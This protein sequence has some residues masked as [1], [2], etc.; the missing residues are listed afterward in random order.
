MKAVIV[1][2]AMV[3]VACLLAACAPDLDKNA[4]RA[5]DLGR[6]IAGG[7]TSCLGT[8]TGLHCFGN[9]TGAGAVAHDFNPLTPKG[10]GSVKEVSM[11]HGSGFNSGCV[12]SDI[13]ASGSAPELKDV[14]YCWVGT[15][16]PAP[17]LTS[18]GSP[19]TNMRGLSAGGGQDCA[20]EIGT[21]TIFCWHTPLGSS[22]QYS[23]TAG[24]VGNLGRWKMISVASGGLF[25]C[26]VGIRTDNGAQR[27]VCWGANDQGQLG[28]GTATPGDLVAD[29]VTGVVGPVALSAG[30][31]HACAILGDHSVKCWGANAHG[32]VGIGDA[33]VTP[34]TTPQVVPGLLYPQKISAGNAFTCVVL[35][36]QTARCWG[37]NDFGQLGIGL[38]VSAAGTDSDG[39]Y[40]V[41]FSSPI[42][43]ASPLPVKGL[44]GALDIS[45]GEAHACS[46]GL[47]APKCWGRNSSG[48]LMA[49]SLAKCGTA[50]VDCSLEPVP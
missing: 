41:R 34:V 31:Q 5:A 9:A 21:A 33:S 14:V 43:A 26:G 7:G 50:G 1:T 13:P 15:S 36:D 39:N 45:A 25:A 38:R 22:T 49:P 11:E 47:G 6:V 23:D 16:D 17:I 3:V 28:R 35:A 40:F 19:L 44:S 12:I 42:L 46:S 10:I 29:E 32:E 48:E 2:L 20:V 37:A 30:V 24:P 18:N 27:V 8:T 4:I